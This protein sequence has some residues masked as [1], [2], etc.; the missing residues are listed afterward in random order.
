MDPDAH[1]SAAGE[2]LSLML[3]ATCGTRKNGVKV[4]IMRKLAVLA[5]LGR[6]YEVRGGSGGVNRFRCMCQRCRWAEHEKQST[7][8]QNEDSGLFFCACKLNRRMVQGG[9]DVGADE[10]TAASQLS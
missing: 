1:A 4:I 10:K 3:V 6:E 8:G 7:A 5:P 2:F 9:D